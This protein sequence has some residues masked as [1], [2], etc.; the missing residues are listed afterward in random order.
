MWHL[1]K[2]CVAWG[3]ENY[4]FE[5]GTKYG[6]TKMSIPRCAILL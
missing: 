1:I 3:M 6:L 2:V 5:V 4:K